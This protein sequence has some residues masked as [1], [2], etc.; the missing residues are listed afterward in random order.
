[1]GATATSRDLPIIEIRL[2]YV[3][4]ARPN[5]NRPAWLLDPPTSPLLES[6]QLYIFSRRLTTS[7]DSRARHHNRHKSRKAGFARL[8]PKE[9]LL[10]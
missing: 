7:L 3:E 5:S 10:I 4:A 9:D 2:G 1:M 8:R 6:I